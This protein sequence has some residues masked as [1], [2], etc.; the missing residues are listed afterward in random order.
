MEQPQR[1]SGWL[2]VGIWKLEDACPDRASSVS[3]VVVREMAR[4]MTIRRRVLAIEQVS[5]VFRVD[6]PK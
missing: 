1:P 5:F 6:M 3:V 4:R 2:A